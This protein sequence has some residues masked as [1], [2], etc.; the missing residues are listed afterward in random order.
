MLSGCR[1]CCRDTSESTKANVF[2]FHPEQPY[3]ASSVD[4]KSPHKPEHSCCNQ[5]NIRCTCSIHANCC[6]RKSFKPDEN[7][8]N[9]GFDGGS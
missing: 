9:C 5:A 1:R 7:Y 8:S 4:R 3:G 6:R 2:L